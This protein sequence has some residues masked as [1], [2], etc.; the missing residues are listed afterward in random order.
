[1]S[2]KG[3]EQPG[4]NKF[5]Y[6]SYELILSSVTLVVMNL[7]VS[8]LSSIIVAAICFGYSKTKM[9]PFPTV[10]MRKC[11]DRMANCLNDKW[12]CVHVA[13]TFLN[14]SYYINCL[15][16]HLTQEFI[17]I[18][19]KSLNYKTKLDAFCCCALIKNNMFLDVLKNLRRDF[20]YRWKSKT[21]K[22]IKRITV[23]MEWQQQILVY[24]P[25]FKKKEIIF[26]LLLKMSVILFPAR[27]HRH[28]NVL[29]RHFV[30]LSLE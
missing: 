25:F 9:N 23:K 22:N 24:L 30:Q 11:V 27:R 16:N 5:S 13:R 3:P 6:L 15:F 2:K 17:K 10:A 12:N 14:C 26:T 28:G 19:A 7:K 4:W 20:L 29:N 8:V 1:M 21:K 18:T